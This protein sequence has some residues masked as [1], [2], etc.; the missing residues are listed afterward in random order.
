MFRTKS[1]H[2]CKIARKGGSPFF[3]LRETIAMILW[4]HVKEPKV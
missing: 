4:E 3:D 1:D 2:E